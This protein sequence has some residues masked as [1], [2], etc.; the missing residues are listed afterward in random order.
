MRVELNVSERQTQRH[1]I[2]LNPSPNESKSRT[3]SA[4]GRFKPQFE[5][6][7]GFQ[8]EH[9]YRRIERLDET[10]PTSPRSLNSDII[11]TSKC[12]SNGAQAREGG[13][14]EEK[15]RWK[16]H[17]LDHRRSFV[18]PSPGPPPLAAGLPPGLQE[19]STRLLT[20]ANHNQ[21]FS[22]RR[23]FIELLIKAELPPI[24]GLLP[25]VGLSSDLYPTP[26]F[27]QSSDLCSSPNFCQTS[28]RHRASSS[29]RTYVC[30]RTFVGL[31]PDLHQSLDLHPMSDLDPSPDFCPKMEFRRTSTRH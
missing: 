13:E 29:R 28:G 18:G 7:N 26:S 23:T 12:P 24:V 14:E 5:L 21:V 10:N 19:L 4:V 16:R 1:Q 31:L 17:L 8:T 27:L 6:P 9:A 25:V 2:R 20:V 11:K 3:R 22:G 15:K 30:H